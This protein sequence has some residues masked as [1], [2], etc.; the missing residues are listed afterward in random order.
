MT[1]IKYNTDYEL[2]KQVNN[3]QYGLGSSIFSC[4]LDHAEK[5][6]RNLLTGMCN[7]NDF[8]S[9]PLIQSLP[10]GGIKQSGYG[11]FN[12][13]E[14]IYSF[15]RQQSVVID[16]WMFIRTYLPQCLQYPYHKNSVEIVKTGVDIVY[17]YSTW[18]SIKKMYRMVRLLLG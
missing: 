16:R 1:I 18:N 9:V 11:V 14:G 10:F 7:I 15:C 8:A 12:G 5:L 2:I 13:S 17:G 6:Q 4:D 3:N